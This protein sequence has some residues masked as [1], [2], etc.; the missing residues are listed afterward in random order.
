MILT[1]II[2][3]LIL[4]PFIL[5][6]LPSAFLNDQFSQTKIIRLSSLSE[7]VISIAIVFCY[8]VWEFYLAFGLTCILAMQSA[9]YSPAKYGIIKAM[10]GIEK[11][12]MANGIIQALTIGH[13]I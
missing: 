9:I 5:L 1:A 7:V 8:F 3:A 2:N 12:G 10:V 11:L 4:L 13:F 6:F